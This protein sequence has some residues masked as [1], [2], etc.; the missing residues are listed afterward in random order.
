[1]R[2]AMMMAIQAVAGP[3]LPADMRPV[4]PAPAP[5]AP[6]VACGEA[7]ASGA[8]V[9][10][11]RPVDADRLRAVDATRYAEKP[12]RAR[13]TIGKVAVSGEAEQGTLP[14]GMSSPRAMVKF[15]MPF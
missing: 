5:D 10:C 1:M 14:N 12:I 4:K 7:D 6:K 13:T 11:G 8:I 3:P 15:R 2:L 9:I